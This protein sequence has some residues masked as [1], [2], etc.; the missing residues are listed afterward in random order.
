MK[1]II[2][3]LLI[4]VAA[5]AVAV[6]SGFAAWFSD[7]EVSLENTLAAGTWNY[8]PTV[9]ITSPEDGATVSGTEVAIVATVDDDFI[10]EFGVEVAFYC[11]SDLIDVVTEPPYSVTWDI[12]TALNGTYTLTAVATDSADQTASASIV[13]TVEN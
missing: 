10:A 1:R 11:G 5:L 8:S 3:G 7:E 4:L 12:T 9:S 2:F 6:P 13:V